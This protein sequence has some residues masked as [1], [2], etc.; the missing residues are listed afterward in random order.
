MRAKYLLQVHPLVFSEDLPSLSKELQSDFERLFKPILQLSPNDG[1]I[2][3]CHK[4]KGKLKGH[5]SLEIIYNNQE[6][7]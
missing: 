5:H 3:S 7:R 6:Y 4:F 1:G 2:L